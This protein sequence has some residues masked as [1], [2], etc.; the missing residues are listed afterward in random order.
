MKCR[1]ML[2]ALSALIA[3]PPTGAEFVGTYYEIV[4]NPYAVTW[5]IYAQFD[6]GPGDFVYAVAGTPMNPL[7]FF[8]DLRCPGTLYQ[9]KFGNDLP[10]NPVFFRFFPSLE[11]DTFVTIGR[12]TSE[13]DATAL[14]PGWPGFGPTGLV[15][16][17]SGWFITPD[18]PQGNPDANNRVLLAQLS[19]IPDGGADF[20][21]IIGF[22]NI[23]GFSGGREFLAL[24]VF[25]G[26]HCDPPF[27]SWDLD[28]DG[29]TGINDLLIL[30][31]GWGNPWGIDDLLGLLDEWGIC[32]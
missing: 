1:H 13:D 21:A 15:T 22:I 8:A 14:A 5:R 29:T 6:G 18:D 30:L 19:V 26:P 10:P 7:S 2:P 17:S 25:A 11:F 24:N 16:N 27:C 32:I 4:P 9:S 28:G 12:L 23:A 3:A 20:A 31:A